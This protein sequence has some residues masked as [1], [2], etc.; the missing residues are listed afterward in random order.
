MKWTTLVVVG[1]VALAGCGG[2]D[3]NKSSDSGSTD[4]SAAATTTSPAA[5]APEPIKGK[6]TEAKIVKTAGLQK[7]GSGYAWS[8]GCEVSAVAWDKASVKALQ[9]SA[10]DPNTVI[11][12]K[13]GTAAIAVVQRTYPCTVHASLVLRGIK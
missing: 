13:S 4:T 5:P 12:N 1:V 7:K 11:P 10:K 8:D 9:K 2:G 3:D 6:Y